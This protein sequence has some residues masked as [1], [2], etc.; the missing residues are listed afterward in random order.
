VLFESHDLRHDE[1]FEAE[2]TWG[3]L[4]DLKD[5]VRD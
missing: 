4:Y 3:A 5:N 2:A 1:W